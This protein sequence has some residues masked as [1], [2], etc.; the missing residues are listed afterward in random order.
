MPTSLKRHRNTLLAKKFQ[1]TLI[2]ESK[3]RQIGLIYSIYRILIAVFLVLTNFNT[4]NFSHLLDITSSYLLSPAVE[5]IVLVT[6]IVI[7]IILLA[8]LFFSKRYSRKQLLCGLIID[9]LALTLLMYSGTA[10][11]L[12]MGLLFMVVSATS[13]MLLKVSHAIG[14]TLI[15]II[16]LIIQQLY[17]SY[18]HT[19]ALLTMTDVLMLSFSLLAVG[20]LSWSVSQRLA[21][22]ESIAIKHSNEVRRLNAINHEV[23]KMMVNGVIVIGRTGQLL[24]INER[25]RAMLRLPARP[26]PTYHK[27]YMFDLEQALAKQHPTLVNWYL[28]DKVNGVF[29]LTIPQNA[30]RPAYALRVSK[31]RMPE[32]GQLLIVEDLSRE[33]SHAQ[34][35]KLASLGQLSASIAHEIRNPLGAISQASEMLM[36]FSEPNDD[37]LELYTMIFNQTK[38]VNRIIEDVMRLSRQE[39]PSKSALDLATWLPDF[40]AQHYPSADIALRIPKPYRIVFDPDHLEQILINLLANALR[41]T[42]PHPEH[43]DVTV[44]V[45]HNSELTFVD[46][47]DNG[48]GVADKDLTQLFHPF[49]TKSQGGTGLGLYLSKAFSEA[50]HARLIYLPNH[51]QTC[52]RLLIPH[53]SHFL[54]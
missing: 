30:G 37:N 47:L 15:A 38:R 23:I 2:P 49:F 16:S 1:Q 34:Q 54:D 12:Q 25:A 28:Q 3:V 44:A 32:Y 48:T 31:K 9:M 11:E 18:T 17:Y 24:I 40:V 13:F 7:G 22:A 52:F 41:H 33:E 6:Y 53:D 45:S 27:A 20:F 26:T 19:P 35:L 46:I 39:P 43:A 51:P 42:A 8:V 21:L 14:I 29:T 5:D 4:A 10:K 50:N 36:E